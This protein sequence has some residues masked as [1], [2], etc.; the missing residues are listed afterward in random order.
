MTKMGYIDENPNGSLYL[1]VSVSG[2]QYGTSFRTFMWPV[3]TKQQAE[4]LALLFE[5]LNEA[6]DMATYNEQYP[7]PDST[8]IL[9]DNL[10][11]ATNGRVKE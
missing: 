8:K 10:L 5:G 9:F 7:T 6:A 2:T 1:T 4:A 3:D 11:K